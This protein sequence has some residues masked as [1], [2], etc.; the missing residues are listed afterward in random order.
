MEEDDLQARQPSQGAS[1]SKSYLK[2]RLLAWARHHLAMARDSLQRLIRAPLG[3]LLT[4]LA[5][6]IAL[7]LPA[8]L[9][10]SLDSVRVLDIELAESATLTAYLERDVTSE[11]AER[12]LEAFDASQGVDSARLV[13]ADQG[14]EEFRQALGVDDVLSGLESNPLPI[15]IVVLPSDVSV[16]SVDALAAHLAGLTGV[17]EVRLDLEWV[18]KLRQ[19]ARLGTRL[20]LMFGGLFAAGVLLIVGNTIRLGVESRR[21]EIEVVLLIGATRAFVRR[22]FLYSGACYGLGGGLLA[23]IMLEAGTQWLAGPF[24]ALAKSYTLDG[25][26][27]RMDMTSSTILLASSIILGW[28]GAWLAVDRQ[29]SRLT[30]QEARNR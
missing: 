30:E 16:E 28:L 12:I 29:L 5:I 10:L 6:G 24:A 22:P 21:R 1:T 26:L 11:H 19:I 17:D 15:S 4:M 3:T 18:E 9:W 27:P 25:S 8:A 14:M 7:V 20:T 2:A 13:S 23:L